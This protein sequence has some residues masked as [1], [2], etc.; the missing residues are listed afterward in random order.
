MMRV[1]LSFAIGIACFPGIAGGQEM[2]GHLRDGI[3]VTA[4]KR[5]QAAGDV[6][7]ALSVADADMLRL[8]GTGGVEAIARQ[9]PGLR[10]QSF[11]PSIVIFNIRGVSQNDYSDAQEAPI[12]FYEDEVYSSVAG[13]IA[14]RAF[15]LERV[16]VLR[17]PQGTLFGRN[18]TGGL[19]HYVTAKPTDRPEAYFSIT[20]GSHNQFSTQGAIGGPL[21]DSVRARFA[22]TSD[23]HDGYIENRA[24]PDVGNARFFAGRLQLVADTGTNGS[25]SLKLEGLRNADERSAGYYAHGAA[26]PD[27][28]GLG[29]FLSA[30]EDAFG[31]CGGCDVLG[32]AEPD[33]DPFTVGFNDP[34]RFDRT[35]GQVAVRY[36]GAL[37]GMK[38]TMLAD[39]QRLEKEYAEDSDMSPATFLTVYNDQALDQ[40]SGEVRLS[41][42]SGAVDWLVG[43]TAIQ[44][45][46]DN[47]YIVDGSNSAGLR[48]VYGGTLKTGSAAV[49]GQ[50]EVALAPQWAVIVGAR[51]TH[52]RKTYDFVHEENG[53]VDLRFNP[54]TLPALARRDFNDWSG[55]VQVNYRPV[56]TVLLYAGVDRGTKSGGFSAP[57]VLPLDVADIGFRPE[58]LLS[59][60]GGVKA[61]LWNGQAQLALA[62]FHYDYNDYQA[63]ENRDGY[64]LSVHNKDAR[65]SGIELEGSVRP[66]AG[67]NLSGSLFVLDSKIRNVILPSGA[68]RDRRMP[69][70]PRFSASG[71]IRYGWA[72]LGGHMSVGSSWRYDGVQYLT[73]FNAQVDREGAR[74]VGDVQI[75]WRSK[76]RPIALGVTINNVTDRRYR[77]FDIDFSQ[78]FGFVQSAYARPRW[79]GVSVTFGDNR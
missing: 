79:V 13:A 45:N 30:N 18:A 43:A 50:A 27:A 17:G 66:L 72:A 8:S 37:G 53:T 67:L 46:S 16:E 32:Y 42:K 22:F 41:A 60:S 31:T 25:F 6:G 15:D 78:N 64:T 65:I 55:K 69:N 4:Q 71:A 19:V 14:G 7:I 9:L 35:Y 59:F 23:F 29:R 77:L 47:N 75:E 26:A 38:L 12:A 5:E 74:L 73:P 3:V 36:D 61:D 68:I 20:G 21:S 44:I 33:S 34:I 49:F 63:F 39:Y 62:A 70:A 28:L 1:G 10:V 48:E 56:E 58:T 11:S 2:P 24:G 52:D 57:A 54:S 51:Y 76:S 40:Y